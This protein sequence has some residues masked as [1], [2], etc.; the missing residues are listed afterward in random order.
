[1]Q[2]ILLL[3]LFTKLCIM[4]VIECVTSR[5]LPPAAIHNLGGNRPPL[6]TAL[7]DTFTSLK[8]ESASLSL[9]VWWCNGCIR[10]SNSLYVS[11]RLPFSCALLSSPVAAVACCQTPQIISELVS[12][13]MKNMFVVSSLVMDERSRGFESHLC[14]CKSAWNLQERWSCIFF[15]KQETV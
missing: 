8:Q 3:H 1:M 5:A 6:V 15:L 13:V 4:L 9:K 12:P 7:F 2:L 11:C 10:M 14:F